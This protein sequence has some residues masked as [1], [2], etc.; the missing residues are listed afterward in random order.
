MASTCF[1]KLIGRQVFP[2]TFLAM[3]TQGSRHVGLTK[4][5]GCLV[6]TVFL[7]VDHNYTDDPQ[8][9]LFETMI[10]TKRKG[11]YKKTDQTMRRYRTYDEAEAGHN[12]IVRAV[13]HKQLTRLCRNLCKW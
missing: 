12:E 9:I 11:S 7:M 3:C 5:N 1:Y 8:P 2:C 4:I 6:S 13:K 10:F